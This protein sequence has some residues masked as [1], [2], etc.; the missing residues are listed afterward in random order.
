MKC[1]KKILAAAL[2]GVLALTMLVGCSSGGFN[3]SEFI[4][5]V[6]DYEGRTYKDV[7]ESQ[8]AVVETILND[9]LKDCDEEED[10]PFVPADALY[11]ALN[12]ESNHQEILKKLNVDKDTDDCWYFSIAVLAD[13]TSA[14][15]QKSLEHALALN[16]LE[17]QYSLRLVNYPWNLSNQGTVS[18]KTV[19]LKNGTRCLIGVWK[20]IA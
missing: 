16:V 9:I 11:D 18:L 5:Q 7:G 2:T 4:K 13:F 3:K 6:G 20:V 19:T 12:N 15:Y 14:H 1:F 17:N 8:A 10:G